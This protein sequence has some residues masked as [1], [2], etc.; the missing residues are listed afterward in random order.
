M[1][2]AQAIALEWE[3]LSDFVAAASVKEVSLILV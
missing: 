1:I 3:R 2:Q